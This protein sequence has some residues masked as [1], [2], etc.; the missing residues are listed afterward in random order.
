M[1]NLK[2]LINENN[3]TIIILTEH[4]LKIKKIN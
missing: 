2:N 4:L 3:F 1:K